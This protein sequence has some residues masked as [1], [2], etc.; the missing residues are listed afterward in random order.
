MSNSRLR[1]F[2][3]RIVCGGVV[4]VVVTE[5]CI[6]NRDGPLYHAI[7][8]RYVHTHTMACERIAF[9]VVYEC[10]RITHTPYA[11]WH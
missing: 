1:S 8:K 10:E 5:S 6:E 3:I 2:F 7:A 11:Q 9:N 4:V